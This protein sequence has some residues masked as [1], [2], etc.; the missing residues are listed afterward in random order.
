M[1]EADKDGHLEGVGNVEQL[2]TINEIAR[3]AWERAKDQFIQLFGRHGAPRPHGPLRPRR[4]GVL[5]FPYQEK[6]ARAMEKVQQVENANR[7]IPCRWI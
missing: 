4:S 1:A 5:G 6:A 7:E 3:K 2:I